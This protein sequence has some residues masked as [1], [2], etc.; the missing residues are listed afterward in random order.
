MPKLTERNGHVQHF[1]ETAVGMGFKPTNVC[2]PKLT[3]KQNR[4]LQRYSAKAVLQGRMQCQTLIQ[5]F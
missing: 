5:W 2:M 3:E 4:D 1:S